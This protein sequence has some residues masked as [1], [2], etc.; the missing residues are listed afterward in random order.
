MLPLSI[1]R[2]FYILFYLVCELPKK[3]LVREEQ[4]TETICGSQYQTWRFVG[5][6]AEMGA[7]RKDQ[8]LQDKRSSN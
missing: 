8:S 4:Q 6:D 1:I 2:F 5:E 7:D 3:S